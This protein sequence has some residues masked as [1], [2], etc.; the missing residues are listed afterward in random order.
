MWLL[1][2][3]DRDA[4]DFLVIIINANKTGDEMHGRRM[5]PMGG[6][7]TKDWKPRGQAY[8]MSRAPAQGVTSLALT[9]LR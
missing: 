1:V 7:T 8:P 5:S 2:E 9:H 4:H 6:I 3:P